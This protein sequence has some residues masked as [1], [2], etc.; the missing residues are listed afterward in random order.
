MKKH[1]FNIYRRYLIPI[2]IVV[3]LLSCDDDIIPPTPEPP[4]S[5]SSLYTKVLKGKV[6]LENQTEHSNALVYLDSLNRGVGTDSSGNYSM[7]FS[8][9]DSIYNGTFKILFFVN[10]F[11][12]DSAQYVLVG[13]KVKLDSLDVDSVGNL[14]TKELEQLL[15]VEGW[16]DKEE[17]RAGDL[18]TFIGRFTNVT[19]RM[20]HI[21]I[22]SCWQP[23]GFVGLYNEN[24]HQYNLSPCDPV[25]A[26]CDIYLQPNDYYEGQV[27]Y[28]I[29]DGYYCDN[30]IPLP[31]DKFIVVA[32]L[33]IEGRRINYFSN[34]LDNFIGKEWWKHHRGT[35]P[36][37]DWY[38]NKYEYP[39]IRIIE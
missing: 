3:L 37:L 19:N 28:I 36:M 12:M 39:I 38:P 31:E 7:Q 21:F 26:D 1:S 18:I 22:S 11:E 30:P 17:Y 15:L 33:F 32:D 35:T 34:P 4:A 29:P 2:I 5:D 16:T 27:V 25:L 23:F 24:Y 10:E 9:E 8:D 13:G 6:I 20:I 14:P